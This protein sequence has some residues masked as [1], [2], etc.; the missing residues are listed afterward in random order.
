MEFKTDRSREDRDIEIVPPP[1]RA[2]PQRKKTNQKLG[3]GAIAGRRF[4]AVIKA[5]GKLC[6]FL[7]MAVFM[8]SVFIY[9]YTSEK[10]NLRTV[11]FL[12]CKELDPTRLEEVVRQS[13]PANILRI[14]LRLL[15]ARLEQETWVRQVEI[16]RVLPSD[17]IIYVE[18]RTPSIILEL[19]GELMIADRDGTLLDAYDPKYGK[20]DVPVFKGVLGEDADSYRLYKEENAARIRQGLSMLN[21]IDA[22]SSLYSH[23]ISEIDI[24]NQSNLKILL[25]DDTAEVLLGDK[26]Y[27]KRYRMLMDNLSRYQELKSKGNDI[28]TVDLRFGRKIIYCLRGAPCQP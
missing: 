1:D 13:F 12:G 10:F 3:K 7:L 8:L 15:K 19:R 18:E 4:V 9:A 21:E 5:F 27:L 14:D 16:R 2:R 22:G 23:N 24:S 20:L 26:D 28:A 17:L 11:T 6:V 25:V